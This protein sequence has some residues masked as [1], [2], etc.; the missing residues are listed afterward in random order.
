MSLLGQDPFE[1]EVVVIRT[2]LPA[3]H[4]HGSSSLVVFCGGFRR[5]LV[6]LM[7]R[8]LYSRRDR[9]QGAKDVV[10]KGELYSVRILP[11][12]FLPRLCVVEQREGRRRTTSVISTSIVGAILLSTALSIYSIAFEDQGLSPR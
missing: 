6:C 1:V 5:F 12:L 11:G 10:S 7:R 8:D 4:G 2:I 3:M 9:T